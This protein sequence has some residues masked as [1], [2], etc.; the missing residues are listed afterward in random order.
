MTAAR[1]HLWATVALAA[2]VGAELLVR[3]AHVSPTVTT[4]ALGALALTNFAGVVAFHM[5]LR[6]EPRGTK[7]LFVLPL[8]LPLGF[9][10]ALV[11]EALG[12][13]INP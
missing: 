13:G 7:L 3:L 2:L 5:R 10:V 1:A 11:L 4:L 8:L 9:A 12:R 6:A